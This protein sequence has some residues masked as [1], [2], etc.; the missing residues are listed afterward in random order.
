[1]RITKQHLKKII[2]EECDNIL[3][4]IWPF[5]QRE[6]KIGLGDF[7]RHKY[8]H[9][10]GQAGIGK[11]KTQPMRDDGTV[12]V[13]WDRSNQQTTEHRED[14]ILATNNT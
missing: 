7:V 10:W 2:N 9:D 13:Y 14:L 1:M 5:G 8:A 4:E 12:G 3:K 11:I 6:K